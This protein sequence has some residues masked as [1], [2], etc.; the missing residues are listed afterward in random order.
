M[1]ELPMPA[2]RFNLK[3]AVALDQPDCLT[4][5]RRRRQILWRPGT[6][7]ATLGF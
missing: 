3:P 2:F 6:P 1:L 5:F 4:N 7:V